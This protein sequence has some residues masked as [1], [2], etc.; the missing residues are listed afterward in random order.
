MNNKTIYHN[1]P[2]TL[3]WTLFFLIVIITLFI[4]LFNFLYV[5][6]FPPHYITEESD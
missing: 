4:M 1:T 5:Y 6:T 3:G 2:H